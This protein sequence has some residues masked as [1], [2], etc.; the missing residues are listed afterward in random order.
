MFEVQIID[1]EVNE[2]SI[3]IVFDRSLGGGFGNYFISEGLTITFLVHFV[4]RALS[5]EVDYFLYVVGF[6]CKS[7]HHFDY[8]LLYHGS[9]Y[10]THC[11]SSIIQ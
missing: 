10:S 9:I 3:S 1:V 11:G 5:Q 4:H 7:G 2:N 8:T 6:S